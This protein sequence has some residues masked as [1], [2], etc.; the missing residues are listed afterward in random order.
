MTMNITQAA[1]KLFDEC[2]ADFTLDQ[3]QSMAGVSRATLYRRIGSKEKLLRQIADD[4]LI[5][6]DAELGVEEKIFTATRAVVVQHG[7][8]ACTMEQ[9]A[10]EA[11]LGVA[12]L[13]RRFKD[14]K[15]LLA[16]FAAQIKP[17]LAALTVLDEGQDDVEQGLTH[18][19]STA[20]TYLDANQSLVKIM[21][22]WQSAERAYLTSIRQESTSTLN[23]IGKYITRQQELGNLRQDISA[24]DLA[25]SLSGLLFQY[26][27]F[28]PVHLARP[29]DVKS[30]SKTIVKL[31]LNGAKPQK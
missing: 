26:A 8:I 22:S 27:I 28:S 3:L 15:N 14:K 18:I 20:L 6:L 19:V 25:L 17:V 23:Q 30:D 13:Y 10:D 5:S 21:F 4:G 9:I 29:L 2:G 24:K 12:T 16:S 11:G 1:V 31:F 7:F